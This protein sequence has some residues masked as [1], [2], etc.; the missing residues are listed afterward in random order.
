[1]VSVV[2]VLLALERFWAQREYIGQ[3]WREAFRRGRLIPPEPPAGYP[4]PV[5]VEHRQRP[6]DIGPHDTP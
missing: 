6:H 1:V 4:R 2:Y 3:R 5:D